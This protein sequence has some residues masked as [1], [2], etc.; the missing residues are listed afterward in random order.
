MTFVDVLLYVSYS[1]SG[2][3]LSTTY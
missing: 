3:S 1:L 2:C